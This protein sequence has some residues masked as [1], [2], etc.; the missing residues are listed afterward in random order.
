MEAILPFNTIDRERFLKCAQAIGFDKMAAVYKLR[1]LH[2]FG[3]RLLIN[4]LFRFS[5]QT[6]LYNAG[7]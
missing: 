6:N 5:V 4:I 1:K 2:C 7:E 3:R